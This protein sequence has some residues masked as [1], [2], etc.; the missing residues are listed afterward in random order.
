MFGAVSWSVV[1]AVVRSRLPTTR[2]LA[3]ASS[4]ETA[5]VPSM[6]SRGR[7]LSL[8][9]RM[10]KKPTKDITDAT[11]VLK[12]EK[13]IVTPVSVGTVATKEVIPKRE[14]KT[15]VEKVSVTLDLPTTANVRAAAHT[16]LDSNEKNHN[17]LNTVDVD[18]ALTTSV[19]TL[20]FAS[21]DV[22]V[23]TKKALSDVMKYQY[24][25]PVQSES[26]PEILQGKDV[27][28]KARTGTGKTL[29]FLI[30]AIEVTPLVFVLVLILVLVLF[31]NSAT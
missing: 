7:K 20:A 28:V 11:V 13:A 17:T 8:L 29:A 9:S 27:F 12:R 19:T 30:P 4:K 5:A 2:L 16:P 24:T 1:K 15:K 6:E 3:T 10:N 23:N 21:L 14:P 18:T 31:Y 25:T 26:I 22:S